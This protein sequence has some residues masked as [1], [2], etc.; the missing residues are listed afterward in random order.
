MKNWYLPIGISSGNPSIETHD[1]KV[2][3]NKIVVLLII[4]KKRK[5]FYVTDRCLVLLGWHCLRKRNVYSTKIIH[6]NRSYNYKELAN[7]KIT[8]ILNLPMN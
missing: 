7:F 1:T 3:I 8:M 5:L 4:L 2:K 6:N